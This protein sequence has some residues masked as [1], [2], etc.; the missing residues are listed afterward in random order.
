MKKITISLFL[1]LFLL[2]SFSLAQVPPF[3]NYQGV[4]KNIDGT[5]I[6]NTILPMTFSIYPLPEGGT[7]QT[8]PWSET[9][10]AVKVING[11]YS[12]RLGSVDP[13]TNPINPAIFDGSTKF[14]GV[15]VGSGPEPEMS[16]RIALVSVPYALWAGGVVDA[17]FVELAPLHAQETVAQVGLSVKSI[18]PAGVGVWGQS[19]G[20]AG[21]RGSSSVGTAVRGE[22]THGRGVYGESETSVGVEGISSGHVGVSGF[23]TGNSGTNWGVQGITN[24]LGGYAG[25]FDGGMGIKI[26]VKTTPGAPS[27]PPNPEPGTMIF[28]T[29]DNTLYIYDG[30]AWRIH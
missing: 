22:S 28:N 4:L 26:P 18:H 24:S 15:K 13:R 8:A 14:L 29:K 12:V 20:L 1:L 6:D 16:P 10:P 25:Y 23:A 7:P 11:L 2:S 19:D 30:S 17:N 21:V 3:I 9:H 5:L 27:T